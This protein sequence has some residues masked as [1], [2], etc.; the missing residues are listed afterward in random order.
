MRNRSI[1]VV[2][3]IFLMAFIF[4]AAPATADAAV[5]EDEEQVVTR[6]GEL[7]VGRRDDAESAGALAFPSQREVTLVAVR[8]VRD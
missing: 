6:R 7:R 2:P 8:M 3:L 4:P 1:F 5:V